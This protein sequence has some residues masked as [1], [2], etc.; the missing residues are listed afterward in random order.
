MVDGVARWVDTGARLTI[1][2]QLSRQAEGNLLMVDTQRS[3]EESQADRLTAEDGEDDM[4]ATEADE[5][6]NDGEDDDDTTQMDEDGQASRAPAPSLAPW[7]AGGGRLGPLPAQSSR[8][9]ARA[10]P[11]DSPPFVSPW[12]SAPVQGGR[13][14][15]LKLTEVQLESYRRRSELE[16]TTRPA[17]PWQARLAGGGGGRGTGG[18]R[19]LSIL[20]YDY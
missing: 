6:A 20:Q 4:S 8:G 3:E 15:S 11:S 14:L 5:I 17:L 1:D 13:R 10:P 18:R 7:P 2:E 16:K 19:Q 9:T 12:T